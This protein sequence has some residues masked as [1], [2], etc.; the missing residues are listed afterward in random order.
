MVLKY[1][2]WDERAHVVHAHTHDV[3]SV[4]PHG[5]RPSSDVVQLYIELLHDLVCSYQ[6]REP[7]LDDTRFD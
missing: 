1:L 3:T 6:L 4:G 7:K 2:F 5:N